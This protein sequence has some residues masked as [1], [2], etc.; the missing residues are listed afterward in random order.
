M[1]RLTHRASSPTPIDALRWCSLTSAVAEAVATA[2]PLL[3]VSLLQALM[4][5]AVG[6]TF[7][8]L[9]LELREAGVGGW[10]LVVALTTLPVLRIVLGPAWGAVADR[11][12]RVRPVLLVA[13]VLAAAGVA[14]LLALPPWL[15]LLATTLLAL[16]RTGVLPLVEAA[17]VDAVDRDTGRYGL[18]RRWGS[19]GFLL[20]VAIAGITRDWTGLSPFWL[21]TLLSVALIVVALTLREAPPVERVPV[22]PALLTLG[23]DPIVW[24][25][26]VASALHFAGIAAYDGFF[27]VHLEALGHGTTW[28]GVAVTLGIITELITLTLGTWMLRRFGAGPLLIAAMAINVPRWIL[29]ALGTEPWMLVPI[30]VVH[31]F[32]FGAYWLASVSLLSRRA[33]E[34]LTGSVQGLLA[35][36]AGGVGGAIGNLLGGTLV[37]S[38]T[39]DML[40]WTTAGIGVVAT[41]VAVGV[42]SLGGERRAA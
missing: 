37:E 27:A 24:G 33:P 21:G 42:V 5:G 13:G 28:V 19:L 20:A 30:Q 41:L 25:I 7:P 22:L 16:G 8:Y 40:F 26:L 32:G 38:A 35:A 31:G 1:A 2:S 34:R 39:T 10:M 12:G 9:A 11:I 29:T 14:L 3:R 17:S 36:S 23:K 4:F 6:A 15:V 18:V